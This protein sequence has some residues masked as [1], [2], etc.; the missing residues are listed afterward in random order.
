MLGVEPS[1]QE[2]VALPSDLDNYAKAQL[3][4]H[5]MGHYMDD[6]QSVLESRQ[7][8]ETVAGDMIQR[9][10]AM[11]LRVNRNKS[12]V[13][14]I[15]KPFRFCKAKFQL[16]PTGRV[17]VHGCRDGMKRA[18]RKL[19]YFKTQADA[20]LI[21]PEKARQKAA[22][23]IQSHVAYYENFDDHGRVLRLRRLYHVML[24]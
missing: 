8:A 4:I 15:S 17:T 5:G 7:R 24:L 19:R 1:Q 11:G 16:T 2:M 21:T 10:E 13:Q 20:G 9:A 23:T 18:R 22:D 3:S 6:Y 14:D 12:K